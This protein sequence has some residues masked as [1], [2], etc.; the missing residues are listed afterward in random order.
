MENGQ[1]IFHPKPETDQEFKC[2]SMGRPKSTPLPTLTKQH[3]K[4]LF[5]CFVDNYIRDGPLA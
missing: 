4:Y 2:G 5:Y 1:T 3:I